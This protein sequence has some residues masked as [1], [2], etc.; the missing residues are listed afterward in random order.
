[1]DAIGFASIKSSGF[2]HLAAQPV[3]G[4]AHS[5]YGVSP[6]NMMIK[7]DEIDNANDCCAPAR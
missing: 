1:M 5:L 6:E 4:R 7:G 2:L 3:P